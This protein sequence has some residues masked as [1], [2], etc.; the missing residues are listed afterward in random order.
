M[1]DE[2]NRFYFA[3]SGRVYPGYCPVGTKRG[4]NGIYPA[5][6]GVRYAHAAT[7]NAGCTRHGARPVAGV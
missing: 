5:E 6:G 7:A 3:K 1:R 2:C 4:R